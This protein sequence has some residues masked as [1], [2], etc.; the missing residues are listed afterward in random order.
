M[1]RFYNIFNI[2]IS[3]ANFGWK[4]TGGVGFLGISPVADFLVEKNN[5]VKSVTIFY[6][7]CLRQ[8]VLSCFPYD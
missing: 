8:R 4:S 1:L 6:L 3:E 2:G 5:L 7:F